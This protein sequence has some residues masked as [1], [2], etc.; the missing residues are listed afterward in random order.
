[1]GTGEQR[2]LGI[3]SGTRREDGMLKVDGQRAYEIVIPGR[4][5]RVGIWNKR[6][7]WAEGFLKVEI[8]NLILILN[9]L[10]VCLS[11]CVFVLCLVCAWACTHVHTC[12]GHRTGVDS[13][14]PPCR[15][16]GFILKYGPS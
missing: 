1:M 15:A 4:G 2:A 9:P 14:L 13:L 11:L 8:R 16:G 5:D 7:L 3:L 12:E 6:T 10:S